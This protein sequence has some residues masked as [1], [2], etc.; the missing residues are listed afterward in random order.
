MISKAIF[1]A[2]C[3]W[4]IQVLFHKTK[5]ITNTLVGYSGGSLPNPTYRE[6]C[7]GDTGHAE[8]VLVEYDSNI[9]SY[10]E[11]LDIFWECHDPSS[12]NRQGPDIGSQYRSAIF[13]TSEEQKRQ[14]QESKSVLNKTGK[15]KN[16]IVTEIVKETHFYKAEDYHQLYLLKMHD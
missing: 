13:Y 7:K 3:F 2:G 9:I 10:N 4:H 11:L 12:L 6:V 8:V 16:P 1:A 5:G 15:Y 14:A